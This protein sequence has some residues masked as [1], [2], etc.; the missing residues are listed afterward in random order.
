[1]VLNDTMADAAFGQNAMLF[2]TLLTGM[3]MM[4]RKRACNV[5]FRNTRMNYRIFGDRRC[6]FLC[7]RFGSCKANLAA[8]SR[9]PRP[10][11]IGRQVESQLQ[12]LYKSFLKFKER[13]T[14]SPENGS[15]HP[16]KTSLPPKLGCYWLQRIFRLCFLTFWLKASD[17]Q[18]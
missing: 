18:N 13:R 3:A 9:L 14:I 6:C 16:T 1:M 17:F 2:W 10:E 4:Q 5:P 15:T 11:C 12:D 8:R 7:W